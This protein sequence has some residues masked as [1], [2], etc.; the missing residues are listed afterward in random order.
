MYPSRSDIDLRPYGY[1]AARAYAAY[2]DPLFLTY[3]VDSWWFG[4]A[5]TIFPDDLE[6]GTLTG[7]NFSIAQV[8]HDGASCSQIA[9]LNLNLPNFNGRYNGR[10]HILCMTFSQTRH[11]CLNC[12]LT[13]KYTTEP[14]NS[15]IDA[16]TVGSVQPNVAV[17]S[18]AKRT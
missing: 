10:G 15:Q 7:K 9:V 11:C 13:S 5:Q 14:G 12:V 3:A 8:C 18:M 17:L 4:R 2:S 6:S 1:A 16:L